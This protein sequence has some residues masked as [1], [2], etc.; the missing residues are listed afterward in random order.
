MSGCRVS[1]TNPYL[2][3]IPHGTLAAHHN[4]ASRLLFQLLGRHAPG[5][6]YSTHKVKLK[7]KIT[8]LVTCLLD[9]KLKLILPKP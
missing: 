9:I 8:P 3:F 4:L 1:W 5:T 2:L 6:Q 7:A